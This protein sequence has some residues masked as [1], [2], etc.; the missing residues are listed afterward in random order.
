MTAGIRV[1]RTPFEAR[2]EAWE[3]RPQLVDWFW[4]GIAAVYLVVGLWRNQGYAAQPGNLA[5]SVPCAVGGV[6]AVALRRR[7]PI[8]TVVAAVVAMLVEA[9]LGG[10]PF[11]GVPVLFLQYAVARSAPPARAVAATTVLGVAVVGQAVLV[12]RAGEFTWSSYAAPGLLGLVVSALMGLLVRWRLE[13]LKSRDRE[14]QAAAVERQ[15]Q[16]RMAIATDLHDT[17]GH[18]LTAVVSLARGALSTLDG[19]PAAARE[20]LTMLEETAQLGLDRTRGVV[21][22]L[23]SE[24]PIPDGETL[25]ALVQ[26]VRVA[27]RDVRVIA[28]AGAGAA[29]PLVVPVVREALTNALRYGSESPIVVDVTPAGGGVEVR[30]TSGL[31]DPVAPVGSGRGLADLRRRVTEAEG[32]FTAGPDGDTWSVIATLPEESR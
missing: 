30:V 27:G 26:R 28:G 11:L 9:A 29:H 2:I 1:R 5:W 31:A 20:A 7:F 19:D 14:A 15:A 21:A 25:E 22:R 3:A 24:A 6:V 18:A 8:A 32:Q 23:N 4:T 17:V 12:T 13:Q 10:T 16:A